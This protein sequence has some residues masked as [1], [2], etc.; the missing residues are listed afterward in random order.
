MKTAKP[1]HPAM[2]RGRSFATDKPVVI[3]KRTA[4]ACAAI[5]AGLPPWGEPSQATAA[6]P[7]D[8]AD[9]AASGRLRRL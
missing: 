4:L 1:T 2:E 9:Q 3:D 7:A 6:D 8:G 5:S